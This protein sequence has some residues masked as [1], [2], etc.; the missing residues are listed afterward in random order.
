MWVDISRI[1]I[2]ILEYRIDLSRLDVIE[3]DKSNNISDCSSMV[4]IE[5]FELSQLV[6]STRCTSYYSY[7]NKA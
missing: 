3:L 5:I 6:K 4:R 7:K 1:V 2:A